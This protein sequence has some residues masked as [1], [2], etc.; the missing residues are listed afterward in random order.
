MATAL[1]AALTPIEKSINS[2]E[3]QLNGDK[4]CNK[5]TACYETEYTDEKQ[6]RTKYEETLYWYHNLLIL[7]LIT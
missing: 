7:P 6:Y 5:I 2:I 1:S 4:H 3:N